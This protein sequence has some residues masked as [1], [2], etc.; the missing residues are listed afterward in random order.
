[1]TFLSIFVSSFGD[2]IGKNPLW[3]KRKKD[4]FMESSTKA[5]QLHGLC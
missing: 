2:T 4:E 1:M 3:V 5:E